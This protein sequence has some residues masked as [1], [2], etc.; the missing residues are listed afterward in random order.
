[1]VP[2]AIT[3]N[4]LISACEKGKQP[5]QALEIL[6]YM[7]QQGVVPDVITYN[8]LISACEKGLQP[9]QALE[10][11]YEIQQQGVV[12]DVITYNAFISACE[13]ALQPEHALD[14]FAEMN[15]QQV[16]PDAITYHVLISAFG[17]RPQRASTA[18]IS[19]GP[20]S[21]VT[22]PAAPLPPTG[23]ARAHLQRLDQFL[24]KGFAAGAG[25]ENLRGHEA[26]RWC[27]I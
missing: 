5:E 2:N 24:G 17:H 23:L 9:E 10:M 13:R 7:K 22:D 19:A 6:V 18:L 4:A 26:A 15:Q 11:I 21:S 27:P 25:P 1:M 14:I 16:V 8:A 3:Y 12:P 20:T